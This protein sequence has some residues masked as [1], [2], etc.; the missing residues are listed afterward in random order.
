M[1]SIDN[2]TNFTEELL[3][4]LVA[5]KYDATFSTYEDFALVKITSKLAAT[6]SPIRIKVSENILGTISTELIPIEITDGTLKVYFDEVEELI[7]HNLDDLG[8]MNI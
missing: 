8:T 5:E 6:F 3:S 2:I 1:K 7:K 4:K